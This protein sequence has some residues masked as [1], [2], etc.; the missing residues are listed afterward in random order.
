M[1]TLLFTAAAFVAG[2]AAP[3][4]VATVA[5]NYEPVQTP[6]VFMSPGGTALRVLVDAKSL[7]GNE[8]EVVELTFTANSDSGDHR[9][10]VT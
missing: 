4:L 1:K 2:L 3:H 8:V 6:R 10:A 9:H 7:G 5:G